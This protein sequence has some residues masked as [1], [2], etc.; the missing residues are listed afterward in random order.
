MWLWY[1]RIAAMVS[2]A[3][4][5]VGDTT[6][7]ERTFGTSLRIDNPLR[8]DVRLRTAAGIRLEAMVISVARREGWIAELARR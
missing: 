6:T 3:L 5:C 4:L 7:Q 8:S 1:G 2:Y